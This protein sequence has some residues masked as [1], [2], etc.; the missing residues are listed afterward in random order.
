MRISICPGRDRHAITLG[1]TAGALFAFGWLA[2]ILPIH[3]ALPPPQTSPQPA[4]QPTSALR[5]TEGAA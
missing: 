1:I 5:G 4:A 3:E 2:C